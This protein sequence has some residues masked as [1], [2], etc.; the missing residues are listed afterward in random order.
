MNALFSYILQGGSTMRRP[1]KSLILAGVLSLSLTVPVFAGSW[2]LDANGYWYQNDDHSYPAN[3]WQW[4]DGNNDGIAESYYFNEN[5]YLLVNTTTP[6][7]FTVDANG[8]WIVD[9]IVQTKTISVPAS[10]ASTQTQNQNTS[11]SAGSHT[12][13]SSS[14]YDGYTIIVNTNT[15]KYHVPSCRTVKDMKQKN[16]GYSDGSVDL[17]A[18]GYVPCKIC[19]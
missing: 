5:G 4:I 9:G 18:L 8:A 11:A 17:G 15:K 16:M 7:G 12:G 14:P 3:T 10:A 1:W 13:V 6:D 19:H 2:Q